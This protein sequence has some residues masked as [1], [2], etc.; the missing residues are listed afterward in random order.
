MTVCIAAIY[1][2]RHVAGA[3]DRMLTAGDT[4]FQ[5]A[6]SKGRALTNSIAAL[7]AG[8]AHLQ[9]EVLQGVIADIG[10]EIEANPSIWM[11]VRRVADLCAT[12]WARVR[13]E[14]AERAL[15]APLKLNTADFIARQ[16]TMDPDVVEQLT[17]ALINFR[18]DSIET[19]IAGIDESGPHIFTIRDGEVRHCNSVGFAA[20]GSGARHAE[21]QLMMARYDPFDGPAG[22]MSMVHLAKTRA[23]TAP[24]VGAHTDMFFIGPEPGTLAAVPDTMMD[25]LANA[26]R[27]VINAEHLAR[28]QCKNG[29]RDYI[30]SWRHQVPDGQVSAQPGTTLEPATTASSYVAAEPAAALRTVWNNADGI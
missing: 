28:E 4:Q 11:P 29:L 5:S 2:G 27:D 23:E 15:L 10:P 22:A 30:S 24:G 1:G 25:Y 20:I 6:M 18:I 14:R 8:D 17:N 7:I 26:S 3:S 9:S 19:I 21:S 16:R 12:H 13:A